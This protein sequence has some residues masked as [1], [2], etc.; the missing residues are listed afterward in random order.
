MTIETTSIR[1]PKGVR[2]KLK[3]I[4]KEKGCK[5]YQ[6]LLREILWDYVKLRE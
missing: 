1:L 4:A 5:S 6:T 3:A 2:T